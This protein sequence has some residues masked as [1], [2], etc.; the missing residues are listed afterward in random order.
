VALIGL[1]VPRVHFL[2]DYAWFVGFGLSAFVYVG[3]MW[4]KRPH[5]EVI[6]HS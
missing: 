1:V 5:G 6:S 3:L 4:S 2:Y